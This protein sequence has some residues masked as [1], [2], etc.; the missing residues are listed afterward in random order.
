[1]SLDSRALEDLA[2][3]GLDLGSASHAKLAPHLHPHVGGDAAL[4]PT[5]ASAHVRL[6]DEL[7]FP[8]SRG[9]CLGRRS[10]DGRCGKN[11]GVR[12]PSSGAH[13]VVA[14]CGFSMRDGEGDPR[15]CL[16]FLWINRR[17]RSVSPAPTACGRLLSPWQPST[18]ETPVFLHGNCLRCRLG[19][20]ITGAFK[21][22]GCWTN[23]VIGS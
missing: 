13:E 22:Y 17:N 11:P 3:G 16:C 15:G 6:P 19:P 14:Y 5:D 4:A 8:E 18:L 9:S 10:S 7:P 23:S 21:Q 20:P 1:M 2:T 12:R